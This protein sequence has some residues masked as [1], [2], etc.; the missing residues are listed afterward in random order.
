MLLA[1]IWNGGLS[2]ESVEDMANS[3][4]HVMRF[5]GLS[6]EMVQCQNTALPRLGQGT[7]LA[8][9]AGHGV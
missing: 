3:N 6:L 1:G 8:Y 4:L 2:D 7:C 5:L 9:A